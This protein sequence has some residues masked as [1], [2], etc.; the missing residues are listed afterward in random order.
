MNW[1]TGT[2]TVCRQENRPVLLIANIGA[3]D[4]AE[5]ELEGADLSKATVI[6]IDAEH[7]YSPT[8]ETITGGKLRLPAESC[9]EIRF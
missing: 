9:V 3:D 5:L 4:V 7:S 2:E 6:R 1:V 8:G